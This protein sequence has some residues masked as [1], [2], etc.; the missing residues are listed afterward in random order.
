MTPGWAAVFSMQLLTKALGPALKS[1][2]PL[3]P[4]AGKKGFSNVLQYSCL[5]KAQQV[6]S[7]FGVLK[8]KLDFNLNG[9][10]VFQTCQKNK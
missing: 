10:F 1:D 8:K 5:L 9:H 4:S 7:C 2:S 3:G 6:S